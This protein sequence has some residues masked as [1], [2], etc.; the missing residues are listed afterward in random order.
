MGRSGSMTRAPGFVER[1]LRS[2]RAST[3]RSIS[4]SD[5]CMGRAAIVDRK[6]RQERVAAVCGTYS[7]KKSRIQYG[8]CEISLDDPTFKNL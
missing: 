6:K 3:S 1:L 8:C 7:H 2:R 4:Y 5:G